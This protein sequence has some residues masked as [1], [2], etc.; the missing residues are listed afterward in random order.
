MASAL[1]VTGLLRIDFD[2][3]NT[4]AIGSVS[5]ASVVLENFAFSNGTG[6]GQA[7][8]YI[9]KTGTATVSAAN[10]TTLSSV[11]I[12]TQSGGTYTAAIDKVR[13]LYVKN[14]GSQFVRVVM[15]NTADEATFD[16][17]V[18]PGGVLLWSVGS[19]TVES[20]PGGVAIDTVT[21]Y[22]PATTTAATF[23]MVIAG[24]KA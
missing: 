18:H 2:L 12:P 3:T 15:A 11:T 9:R 21:V 8:I 7:N 19:S 23:D 22:S 1:T 14:T 16:A 6:A 10:T 5:D 20:S 13:L 4:Q 17:E 24:T